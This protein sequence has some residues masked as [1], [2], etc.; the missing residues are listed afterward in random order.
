M[1]LNF[2]PFR[3]LDRATEALLGTRQGPRL[4]PMDLYRENDHYVLSADLPG[5]DPGSVD[6][7]VDGQLLT[8]RAERTLTTAENAKWI[9]RE[10]MSG[11]FLRQLNLGQGVDIENIA[12]NYTN[13]VLSVTIPVSERAK[14]RKIEVAA[15]NEQE[16]LT[17]KEGQ[18]SVD[19]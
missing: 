4:M 19:A 3:E 14:P 10:R 9:A 13:G 2:D 15:G 8:I 6:I 5:I 17:V 16:T 11:S 18:K 7:D 1:A 12:A